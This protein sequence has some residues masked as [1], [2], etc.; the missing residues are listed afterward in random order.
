LSLAGLVGWLLWLVW[1]VAWSINLL[2][3]HKSGVRVGD[4][5]AR[6]GSS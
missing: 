1:I 2:R 4:D 3:D 6:L 5:L